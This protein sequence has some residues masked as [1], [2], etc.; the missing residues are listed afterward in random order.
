MNREELEL[1][2]LK[3]T[4]EETDFVFPNEHLGVGDKFLLKL[5]IRNA[6]DYFSRIE[7][8]VPFGSYRFIYRLNEEMKSFGYIGKEMTLIP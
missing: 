6:F 3:E 7:Q 8:R 1:V 4:I 5:A 2:A